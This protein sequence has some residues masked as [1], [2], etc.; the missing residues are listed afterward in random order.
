MGALDR[1]THISAA[2]LLCSTRNLRA[3]SHTSGAGLELL[4][5]TVRAGSHSAQAMT[6]HM[7]APRVYAHWCALSRK[8]CRRNTHL[9]K[10]ARYEGI[11]GFGGRTRT[12][13]PWFLSIDKDAEE[14]TV[15]EISD[16]VSGSLCT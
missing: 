4:G 6:S 13:D 14:V 8:R 3:T 5:A 11:S 16:P 2:L 9:V 15:V 10:N 1:I 7:F 12:E